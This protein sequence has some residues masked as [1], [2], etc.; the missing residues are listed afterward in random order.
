MS[1][2]FEKFSLD[3]QVALVTG[4][5]GLL[6]QEFCKTLA[7]AGGQVVVADLDIDAA[8]R[9]AQEIEICGGKAFGVGVDVTSKES[10][11]GM[12]KKTLDEFGR[13]DVLV[14]SA[15]LDPKF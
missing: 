14:C 4:G 2:I 10:V 15:A 8:K 3:G 11:D 1:N 5:A 7:Q 12:I 9:T 6:G 13:L